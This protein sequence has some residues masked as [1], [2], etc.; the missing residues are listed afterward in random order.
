MNNNWLALITDSVATFG[1]I[2]LLYEGIRLVAAQGLSRKSGILAALGLGLCV[3][4]ASIH[5]D[6][7]TTVSKAIA[8]AEISTIPEDFKPDGD[9]SK[10]LPPAEREK[11]GHFIAQ[12]KYLRS[13]QIAA[14]YN[15]DAK[16]VTFA[17]AQEDVKARDKEIAYLGGLKNDQ[18]T[19]Y[20]DM[21]EWFIWSFLAVLLGLVAGFADKNAFS[22]LARK[23]GT[24]K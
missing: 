5:F 21:I 9:W 15:S 16:L 19:R 18:R 22:F 6:R 17:P 1:A 20:E 24:E 12:E 14:Y 8:S 13:G 2:I 7:Y 3:T 23:T 4:S 10:G 11:I